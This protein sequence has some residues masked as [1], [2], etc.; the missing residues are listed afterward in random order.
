MLNIPTR[1]LDRERKRKGN[2][3]NK[4]GIS[5]HTRIV[6][7][8]ADLHSCFEELFN[9]M[10]S[11]GR[12]RVHAVVGRQGYLEEYTARS[13][14]PSMREREKWALIAKMFILHR[15][16]FL[17]CLL[18]ARVR[19]S[20]KNYYVEDARVVDDLN[21]VADTHRSKVVYRLLHT[22]WSRRRCHL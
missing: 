15:F 5:P 19:L 1:T 18:Y 4:M 6:R 10:R 8:D 21:A 7:V 17:F 3:G 11:H 12:Y 2:T 14:L 22:R 9:W 16:L 20:M 13:D